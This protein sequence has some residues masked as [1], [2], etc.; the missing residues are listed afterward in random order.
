MFHLIIIMITELEH[1]DICP[2]LKNVFL[3]L[4]WAEYFWASEE[5]F[6]IICDIFDIMF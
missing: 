3:A 1:K 5:M 4:F 2:K 6:F